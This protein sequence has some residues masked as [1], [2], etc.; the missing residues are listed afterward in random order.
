MK[1][2]ILLLAIITLPTL[3]QANILTGQELYDRLTMSSETSWTTGYADG[4][5]DGVIDSALG[6]SGATIT[7]GQAWQIIKNYLEAHPE[8]WNKS[9]PKVIKKALDPVCKY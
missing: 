1:R 4:Y 3:V 7:H 9:A 5:M 6:C 2:L 8:V